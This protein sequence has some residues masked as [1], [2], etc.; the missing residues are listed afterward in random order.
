MFYNNDHCIFSKK[1]DF[2]AD[3]GREV[4]EVDNPVNNISAWTFE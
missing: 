4:T 2:G 1:T 3:M